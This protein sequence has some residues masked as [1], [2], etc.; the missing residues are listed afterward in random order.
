LNLTLCVTCIKRCQRLSVNSL[1]LSIIDL[2]TYLSDDDTTP[3]CLQIGQTA[4][5]SP[6][7]ETDAKQI[8]QTMAGSPGMETASKQ[9]GH[10]LAGISGRV[11][12]RGW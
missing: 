4:A 12:D 5:G 7:I 3:V 11:I 6:G 2:I 10:T 8:G 9:I 1:K